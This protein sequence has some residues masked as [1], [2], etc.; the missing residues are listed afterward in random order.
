MRDRYIILVDDELTTIAD[1][2]TADGQPGMLS[3]H[4]RARIKLAVMRA[5]QRLADLEIVF[6]M[7][8]ADSAEL[9][10]QTVREAQ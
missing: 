1:I 5:Q 10:D 2:V 9:F 4:D 6:G 3:S 8:R 7:M